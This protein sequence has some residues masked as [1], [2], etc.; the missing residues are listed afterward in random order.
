MYFPY[1]KENKKPLFFEDIEPNLR[2]N[3]K[4]QIDD[5]NID[6][7]GFS[8]FQQNEDN[9]EALILYIDGFID[10]KHQVSMTYLI[11]ISPDFFVAYFLI[12]REK[13]DRD[14]STTSNRKEKGRN[15]SVSSEPSHKTEIY[16]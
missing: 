7:E 4:I 16:P 6:A 13:T 14:R 1:A 5:S 8:I 10:I 9:T 15:L 2:L 3:G 11:S 12:V